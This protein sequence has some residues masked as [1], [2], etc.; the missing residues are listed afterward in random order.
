MENQLGTGV[1]NPSKILFLADP[2]MCYGSYMLFNGLTG[3]VGDSNVVTYPYKKS[4]YG[5]V[6]DDYILDDGKRGC[7]GPS[8]FAR[9]REPNEWT[10]EQIVSNIEKFFLV[11][12]SSPRTYSMNAI[13]DFRKVFGGSLPPVI[14]VDNEDSINVRYELIDAIKP[15]VSFKREILQDLSSN[16]IYPLPFSSTVDQPDNFDKDIDVFFLVGCT[17]VIRTQIRDMLLNDQR[18]K[19]YNI[20]AGADD[21]QRKVGYQEYLESL[22]RS[23]INISA[24][25]H[26][27]ETVRRWEMG[28]FTGLQMSDHLPIIT[29]HPFSDG[30]NKIY[31]QNNLSN[32]IDLIV[33]Y[34]ENDEERKKIGQAGYEHCSKY[35]TSIKRAEYVLEIVQKAKK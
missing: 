27:Y 20:Y 35:H 7:T 11:I 4:W 24:R 21:Q 31:Y 17:S 29:P 19:K 10:F 25:G 5:I 34:L 16:N 3:L 23:K 28:A 14:F 32:I 9:A 15:V 8:E 30:I 18:L 33:Y 22:A 12:V 13:R 2:Q 26:G 6:H 1:Q